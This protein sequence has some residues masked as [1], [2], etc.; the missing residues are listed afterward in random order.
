MTY[1]EMLEKYI[2]KL[3]NTVMAGDVVYDLRHL[4]QNSRK[5]VRCKDCQ[6]FDDDS[7]IYGGYCD[8]NNLAVDED[9]F[10]AWAAR[11]ETT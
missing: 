3:G 5:T 2:R 10:C 4:E 7:V 6:W 1:D 9:D 11:R 8:K